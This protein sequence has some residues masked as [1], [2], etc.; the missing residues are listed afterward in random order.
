MKK[1]LLPFFLIAA[2]IFILDQAT[3]YYI[4][5]NIGFHESVRELPFF[6]IIY[7]ENSGSAFGMFREFGSL[8]FIIISLAAVILLTALIIK[9][10]ANAFPYSLLLGGAAGNLLDRMLY[11]RV[12]DFLDFYIGPHHWPAFNVADS[13]LTIGII[14]LMIRTLLGAKKK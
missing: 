14:L 9:D 2:A 11:G 1:S 10:R 3:K 6:D 7:T 4:K 12:T 5:A 8:F 13:A